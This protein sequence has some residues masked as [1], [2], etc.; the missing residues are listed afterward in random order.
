MTQVSRL[1]LPARKPNYRF[2]LTPLADAMLQ[3][4]IFFMLSSSLTPY[5]L[6][7]LKT[8]SEIGGT[9]VS[10]G[11]ETTATSP[12]DSETVGDIALWTIEADGIVVGGQTFGFDRLPD[13]AAALGSDVAPA[14]VVL[15]LNATAQVQDVATVL[16]ALQN[17]NISSV[18]IATEAG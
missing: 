10:A 6:L 15:L 17:A 7:T 14:E 5:S 9:P 3:L 16:E 4:L 2:A 18:K 1:E 12:D 11:A 13:L 8:A